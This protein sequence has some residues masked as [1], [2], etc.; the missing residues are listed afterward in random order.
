MSLSRQRPATL[1]PLVP[2]NHLRLI[3]NAVNRTTSCHKGP[4]WTMPNMLSKAAIEGKLATRADATKHQGD[5]RK[6]VA[7][8]NKTLDS[9]IGPLNVAAEYVDTISQG[10]Y[11]PEDHGQLQRRLQRHQEQP[12]HD[13][14]EPHQVRHG[15]ADG[16]RPGGLGQ[17]ADER[18]YAAD[19]RGRHGAGRV[20][21]GSMRRPWNRWARTSS[22]TRT[23]PSRRRRSPS[24]PPRTHREGGKAV[25]GDGER[26]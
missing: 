18:R 22:R 26:R 7:G 10:R 14:R 24:S 12:E 2:A 25:C 4:G 19:V 11:P 9:V 20:G 17:P 3:G 15:R 21:R 8:V 16:G 23:M 13:G 6:I 5:F 1:T